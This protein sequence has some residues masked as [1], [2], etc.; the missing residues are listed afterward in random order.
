VDISRSPKVLSKIERGKNLFQ[1]AFQIL[2]A[3]IVSFPPLAPKQA[4]RRHF[5]NYSAPWPSRGPPTSKQVDNLSVHDPRH[6]ET[7]EERTPQSRSHIAVK[8]EMIHWLGGV[9][10]W[11]TIW[12]DRPLYLVEGVEVYHCFSGLRNKCQN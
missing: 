10:I 1:C 5:P 4:N 12:R 11:R 9:P 6:P 2:K 3:P 7:I 8:K